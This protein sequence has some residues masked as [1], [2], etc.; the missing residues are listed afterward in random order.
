MKYFVIFIAFYLFYT[1]SVFTAEA[2]KQSGEV[3]IDVFINALIE[4]SKKKSNDASN[5]GKLITELKKIKNDIE[6]LNCSNLSNNPYLQNDKKEYNELVKV[7]NAANINEINRNNIFNEIN[8]LIEDC[9]SE[10]KIKK[11]NKAAKQAINDDYNIINIDND[12]NQIA[13]DKEKI[14]IFLALI[15]SFFSILFSIITFINQRQAKKK[16]NENE[17]KLITFPPDNLP[18]NLPSDQP[19]IQQEL[20][21]KI[22]DFISESRLYFQKIENLE[23]KVENFNSLDKPQV[24]SDQK[25][26]QPSYRSDLNDKNRYYFRGQN[27]LFIADNLLHSTPENNDIFYLEITGNNIIAKF[28]VNINSPQLSFSIQFPDNTLQNCCDIEGKIDT[29]KKSIQTIEEGI[30]E[31]TTNG[32]RVTKFAKIRL[33]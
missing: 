26:I 18:T 16:K 4:K 6:F 12:K 17:N 11:E 20:E 31:R 9:I 21:N 8:Y 5:Y 29:T 10:Q 27:N 3:N 30:A 24:V 32:W 7:L 33:V 19:T 25:P 2:Q 14:F 22:N 15:F 1:S 23:K 28:G 13:M